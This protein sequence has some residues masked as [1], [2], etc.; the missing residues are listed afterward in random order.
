M[1]TKVNAAALGEAVL[2]FLK[3]SETAIT[4]D[5]KDHPEH[6]PQPGRFPLVVNPIISK[7]CLSHVLMDVNVTP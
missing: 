7:T 3:W 5:R 4:F 1:N 6:I 2:A